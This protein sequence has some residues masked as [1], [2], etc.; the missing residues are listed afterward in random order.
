LGKGGG[1]MSK[2]RRFGDVKAWEN[3]PTEDKE[4]VESVTHGVSSRA[5]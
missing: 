2:G 5:N 4:M 3:G 1:F